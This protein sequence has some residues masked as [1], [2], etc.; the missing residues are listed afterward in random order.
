MSKSIKLKDDNYWDS[1]SVVHKKV[2]A[3][4]YFD[5]LD[6]L[7]STN[8]QI[9]TSNSNGINIK[10]N[11]FVSDKMPIVIFGSDNAS[12]EPVFII[13]NVKNN[14]AST[15]AGSKQLSG[16][17]KTITRSGHTYHI[18]ASQYSNYWILTPRGSDI[19]VTNESL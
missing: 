11:K 6:T 8:K 12:N 18:N 7:T 1:S 16:I 9:M 13:L 15:V 10:I 4:V 19:T 5:R 2:T 17:G 3:D 14:T